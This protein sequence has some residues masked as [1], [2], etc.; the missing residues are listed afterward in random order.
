MK[1]F[2]KIFLI[3]VILS[4]LLFPDFNLQAAEFD[5]NFIISDQQI[6]DYKAMTLQDIKD[7][8]AIKNSTLL[9]FTTKDVDGVEKNAAQ[10]IYD[11]AQ[12][13]EINPKFI[14]VMLQKEQ[15]VIEDSQ[16][17][18]KQYDWAMG[19]GV[20]DDCSLN[21][22]ALLLFKGFGTQVDKAT[23]RFRWYFDNP[24]SY[25]QAGQTYAIDDYLVTPVNQATANL[26]SYTPHIHGNYL[27]WKIWQRWF[28]QYYPDGSLV[29]TPN[30]PNVYLLEYGLKRPIASWS[31]FISRYD[32]QKIITI[33]QSELDK[34]ENGSLIQFSNYSLLRQEDGKIFLL[35][36]DKLRHIDTMETFRQIGFNI[37]EVQEVSSSDL[38]SFSQ[39]EPIT[40][41]SIY[42]LGALLQN[43]DTGGI[44]FVQNGVKHPLVAPEIMKINYPRYPVTA[45]APIELEKYDDGDPIKFKDGVLLKSESEPMVYIVSKGKKLPIRDENTFNQLNYKWEQIITVSDNSLA[46][47][48]LGEYIDLSFKN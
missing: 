27:F 20:C 48:P 19:Y 6:F 11:T 31:A 35:V 38:S 30:N 14:L 4:A 28:K 10:I 46:I 12:K 42:P 40:I 3:L 41:A 23:A 44:Y 15:S 5:K 24:T 8:L 37:L 2:S 16:P 18:A 21:D 22:P 13:Y 26:Y 25:K 39:G 32:P 1:Y 29:K 47:L 33:S 7:F 36:D 45:V 34:Y 43:K 9:N 17:T